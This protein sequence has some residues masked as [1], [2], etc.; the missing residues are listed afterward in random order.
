MRFFS[1]IL[2]ISAALSVAAQASQPTKTDPCLEN[3]CL[4]IDSLTIFVHLKPK[5]DDN[6]S[7]DY[8]ISFAD[9]EEECIVEWKY[10]K[11]AGQ[12][13]FPKANDPVGCDGGRF[14]TFF[15]SFSTTSNFVLEASYTYALHS[16]GQIRTIHGRGTVDSNVLIC[17][18]YLNSKRC[19]L[20]YDKVSEIKLPIYQPE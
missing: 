10:G 16:T 17:D 14:A 13:G 7:L 1:S 3:G 8:T 12:R 18:N 6:I 20:D 5:P 2:T 4:S 19:Q 9:H 15:D 11:S